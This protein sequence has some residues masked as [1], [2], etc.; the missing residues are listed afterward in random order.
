MQKTDWFRIIADLKKEGVSGREIARRLHVSGA[1]IILWKKGSSP[2]Y[3]DGKKLI[4]IWVRET[5]KDIDL[6]P[7]E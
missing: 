6:L 4:D 1:T 3:D 2:N 7:K 5:G